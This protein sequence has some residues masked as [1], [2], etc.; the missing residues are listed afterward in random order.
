MSK[1]ILN[2]YGCLDVL[3]YYS[4]VFPLLKGY[5]KKKEI[6][7]KIWLPKSQTLPFFIKRGSKNKPLF[8]DD[9]KIDSKFLELRS[10]YSL[11]DARKKLTTKQA[12]MWDYFVPR[13]V[14]EFFYATNGE[15][16]D[17]P[18][19]RI[20]F[21][22]DR[23]KQTVEDARQVTLSLINEI[24]NDQDFSKLIK[25]DFFLMWTGSSFHVYLMLKKPQ[26]HSFYTKYL[27]YTDSDPFASFTGRWALN[28]AKKFKIKVKGG[29][30]RLNKGII[31]DPS[32]TPS[33]KLC[34]APFSLHTRK[35][36]IDGV[37]IPILESELKDPSIVKKLQAYTY[38][39][40]LKN[41]DELIKK[42][43]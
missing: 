4:K 30:E 7:T 28:I 40:V 3:N 43:S 31:I 36:I 13:K 32:Q 17:K 8:I 1:D 24:R 39:D 23:G 20:F 9:I 34:R 18:I 2:E 21:D 6:A 15:N 38:E 12:L 27:S 41:I 16:V 11:K 33:G 14:V 35:G 5:L 25:Y 26:P 37:S 22:I 42:L 10:Q 19:S 29:H